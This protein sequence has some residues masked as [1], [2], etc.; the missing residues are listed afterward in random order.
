MPEPG[1]LF[2]VVANCDAKEIFDEAPLYGHASR[3]EIIRFLEADD[4]ID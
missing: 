2:L 4:G 3:E 1:C